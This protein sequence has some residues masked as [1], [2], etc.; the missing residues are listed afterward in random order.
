MLSERASSKVARR[1][2][3]WLAALVLVVSPRLFDL[4]ADPADYW[5]FGTAWGDEGPWNYPSA[6]A[7]LAGRW[8]DL[9]PAFQ[10]MVPVYA[11]LQRAVFRWQGVGLVS[12]RFLSVVCGLLT[13]LLIARMFMPLGV[14]WAAV[15][16]ALYG[17]GFWTIAVDRLATPESL[18]VLLL[19]CASYLL[20]VPQD[21]GLGHWTAAGILSLI[22]AL[23]K[24]P[25]VF[26]IVTIA[27]FATVGGISKRRLRLDR[28]S[29]I[30]G[31][32]LAASALSLY[33]RPLHSW[34]VEGVV[35]QISRVTLDEGGAIAF[36]NSRLARVILIP[37]FYPFVVYHSVPILGATVL[38]LS[39]RA[40]DESTS[41]R[42]R[43]ASF[44][45]CWLA[46]WWV[47]SPF[48]NFRPFRYAFLPVPVTFLGVL[49]L[50]QL[51]TPL[52]VGGRV[53][54]VTFAVFVAWFLAMWSMWLS[55]VSGLRARVWYPLLL[56]ATIIIAAVLWRGGHFTVA[57][58]SAR[59]YTAW[60]VAGAVLA[61]ASVFVSWAA[62][63]THLVITAQRTVAN[64]SLGSKLVCGQEA[65]SLLFTSPLNGRPLYYHWNPGC[66]V[67]GHL[68]DLILVPRAADCARAAQ[69][70]FFVDNYDKLLG[71]PELG[72]VWVPQWEGPRKLVCELSLSAL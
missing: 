17:T 70:P 27:L 12:A 5:P 8:P 40:H 38:L 64:L 6:Y 47:V 55:D 7:S 54:R 56:I 50:Q 33:W 31:V 51:G 63:R 14:R 44:F 57:T 18:C 9:R 26:G 52:V 30:A 35:A 13:I 2:T 60:V 67:E 21:P 32:S 68:A 4:T 37:L 53:R 15:A 69:Y 3:P 24:P 45:V 28:W 36:A 59:S 46:A 25:A 58:P 1:V 19:L 34:F 65:P 72:R 22:A 48:T 16:A 66:I 20:C 62:G 43:L 71:L 23:S 11:A 42:N 41:L 61:Q 29:L 10:A 39:S 49:G